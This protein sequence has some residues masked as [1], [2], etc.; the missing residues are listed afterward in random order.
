MLAPDV[1]V[2]G[3]G[4][5]G[6]VAANLLADAG[7]AVL[8]LE[9]EPDPGG[10]VRSAELIQPGF[11]HDRFSSFY[12]LGAVSPVLQRLALEEHGLRWRRAPVAVAHVFPDGATAALALDLART[13]ASVD[14]FAAGDGAAWSAL[15]AE[16]DRIGDAIVGALLSPF[17]PVAPLAKLGARLRRPRAVL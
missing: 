16:W 15:A 7:C 10:A 11:V 8:V 4:P 1:V 12:P 14:R 3:A 13:C 6:L 17:P 2:I 9:A 5:N